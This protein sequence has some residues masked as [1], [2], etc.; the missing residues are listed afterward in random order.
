MVDQHISTAV[1]QSTADLISS[2]WTP[3]ATTTGRGNPGAFGNA[4]GD[5]T[6]QILD[7]IT[8]EHPDSG[9]FSRKYVGTI[10]T[11]VRVNLKTGAI[12]AFGSKSGTTSSIQIDAVFFEQGY[13]PKVGDILDG[14]RSL[15]YEIKA[16]VNGYVSTSQRNRYQRLIKT[17]KGRNPRVIGTTHTWSPSAGKFIPTT[18]SKIIRGLG[19]L[20]VGAAAVAGPAITVYA[21]VNSD[22]DPNFVQALKSFEVYACRPNW[23]AR[24]QAAVDIYQYLQS[25]GAANG[26]TQAAIIPYL[27]LGN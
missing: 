13:Q 14:N 15:T 11:D 24:H 17:V 6:S 20:G 26:M 2:N 16:G 3:P 12:E 25:I 23:D 27:E 7:N 19:K 1:S 21:M 9:W 18:N 5:K 22:S 10:R 4:V 8:I